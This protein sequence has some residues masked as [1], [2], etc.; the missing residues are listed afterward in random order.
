MGREAAQKK[1]RELIDKFYRRQKFY[2][3]AEYNE[4]QCRQDFINPLFAALGWDIENKEDLAPSYRAVRLENRLVGDGSTRSL[5]YSFWYGKEQVFIVEAKK[6][7]VN[8]YDGKP[9]KEAAFQLRRYGWS[10][11]LNLSIVTNFKEIAVYDCTRKPKENDP[12]STARLAYLSLTDDA[13]LFK[14]LGDQRDGFDYLWETFGYDSVRRGSLQRYIQESDTKKGILAVDDSFLQFLEEQ[15]KEFARSI[16]RA[17]KKMSEKNLNFAVQ[18]IIDRIVFLRFAEDR[19]IERM[20][21]LAQ[22]LK[23]RVPGEC[24]KNIYELFELADDKYNSGLFDMDNDR[25]CRNIIVDNKLLID[26]VSGL[27]FPSPYDFQAMPVEILGSAYERF[28]GKVIRISGKSAIVEEKPEVRKAGGVY[29]TPQYIVNYIVENTVGTLLEGKSATEVEKIKIIDPAC[30]SGSFLLGAYQYLL[31]WHHTYYVERSGALRSKISD[32]LTPEGYLTIKEKKRIL[33]N[34][35]FGVDLDSHAV[36]FAKMSLLLKCMEGE[37][38]ETMERLKLY[39]ERLLPNIDGN[40]RCGNSL[41]E[42][43]YYQNKDMTQLSDDEMWTINA[44]DWCKTFPAIFRQGG[45]DIVIGNPPYVQQSMTAYFNA[46]IAEYLK[47][48]YSSSMGRLNT[49]G[50]FIARSFSLLLKK[51]GIMGVIVP[52]T[53]LTQEY[54]QELRKIILSNRMDSLTQFSRPVFAQAVVETVILVASA[55]EPN[56]E[57]R[58]RMVH[59]DNRNFDNG[60]AKRLTSRSIRQNTF[61]KTHSNSFLTETTEA[62]LKLKQKIEKHNIPLGQLVNINQAIALKHDRSLSLFRSKKSHRYK[63]VI[64]G[65]HI[66]RYSLCWGGD[67]LAYDVENIHS[68]KRVD[69]FEVS[70]KILFRRVGER[71]T[72]AYDDRQFYALNTL[73]VMTE[74]KPNVPLKILLAI[75]NSKLMDFYYRHFLKSTKKVFSEIQARQV[76]QLPFPTLESIPERIKKR[77]ID[78]VEQILV[79]QSKIHDVLDLSAEL[80]RKRIA[81]IDEQID[82]LVYELYGLTA[83]EIAVIEGKN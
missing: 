63:P 4:A 65:R 6:P 32:Y 76:A 26:F 29:Y 69:I 83:E 13:G 40:I 78:L 53:M 58:T 45:F 3:S 72:A 77:L 11:K 61:L 82:R 64:D 31:D 79:I 49:F 7:S 15:R 74:K 17:N 24:Y 12:A 56:N 54:Y 71:L 35:I 50:F 52:N 46:G 44:F 19:G 47:M 34:N 22:A 66:G 60:E 48:K 80:H 42:T 73:V 10:A 18:Q 20:G 30:G 55:D 2:E 75:F 14:T 16:F 33:L 38:S 70:E 23:T 81:I 37:T 28:L 43:D 9:A 57:H 59:Y 25:V 41:I 51:Q 68:C 27:Y 1:I 8:L 39:R 36:E 21:S 5:D 67:Y 62:L